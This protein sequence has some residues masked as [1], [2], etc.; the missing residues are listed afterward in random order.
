[1]FSKA[2]A[3]FVRQIDPEGSLIHVS[4]LNDSHKLVP[5][6]LVV[7]RNRFWFWQKPKYQPTDFK[8]S[9]LLQGDKALSPVVSETEFLTYQGTYGDKL[10]GKLDTEVGVA[11]VTV[12]GQGSSK[13]HSSFGKLKKEELEVK[14]L[15]LDSKDRLVD[16][17]HVLVQQLEK[18]ADILAVVKE[19][20]ITTIPC[21][22][23]ETKQDQCSLQG[24]LAL[25]GTLGSTVKVCLRDSNDMHMDSDVSLEIPPGT[26]I[27]YSILELEIKKDGHY[28]LCLQPGAIGGFEGDSGT[29]SPSYDAFNYVHQVDG[30]EW[31]E[32]ELPEKISLKALQNESPEMDLSLLAEL[33]ES[34]RSDLFQKLK[35]T[36]RD[37]VTLSYVE[38][39]LE[40]WCR[41]KAF[42]MTN[43][44][45]LS[46]SQKT[47][48]SAVLDLLHPIANSDN[49]KGESGVPAYLFSA[50]LLVSALEELPDESL[51]LLSESCPEFLEAVDTLRCRLEDKD[52]DLSI[53]SLPV[54]LQDDRNFELANQLLSTTNVMLRRETD[55]LWV[56]KGDKPGVPALVLYISIHGLSILCCGQK[57]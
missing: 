23:T 29:S 22:V 50:H 1:M 33:P 21:S 35:E 7:K 49:E 46:V 54:M 27:A 38:Y 5:M 4:R 37:R 47:T 30:L 52:L 34:T 39:E 48:A 3:K 55:R 25:V 44:E 14:K 42:D 24:V 45:D 19:R 15:L 28:D 43:Q 6:S 57:Q 26:V 17:G 2:T 51:S 8:L 31:N 40:E 9:D 32:Q 12:E 10:S 20:I 18:R 53:H 41:G 11:S 56:E 16:M 13:L 36:M